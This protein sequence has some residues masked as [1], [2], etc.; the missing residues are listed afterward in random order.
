MNNTTRTNSAA[1]ECRDRVLIYEQRSTSRCGYKQSVTCKATVER[2]DDPEHHWQCDSCSPEK[3]VTKRST[4]C[5]I[6]TDSR[7]IVVRSY[8]FLR[9]RN[10]R[11]NPAFAF[12]LLRSKSD[13]LLCDLLLG[14]WH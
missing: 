13:R 8:P 7:R 10:F 11:G 1:L 6:G 2:I 4:S 5:S 3:R 14:G 9:E 12:A